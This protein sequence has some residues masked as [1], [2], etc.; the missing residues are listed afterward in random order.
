MAPDGCSYGR[1]LADIQA[2]VAC[3]HYKCKILVSGQAAPLDQRVVGLDEPAHGCGAVLE[4]V[5]DVGNTVGT[6]RKAC[7]HHHG[8]TGVELYDHVPFNALEKDVQA[9][10]DAA[11][12]TC[13]M[14]WY[15]PFWFRRQLPL[16]ESLEKEVPVFFLK[17]VDARRLCLFRER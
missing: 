9:G 2:T 12:R 10:E 1:P 8:A 4:Q 5:V 7:R 15:D 16:V 14:P 11:A 13:T 17:T 3:H 6:E